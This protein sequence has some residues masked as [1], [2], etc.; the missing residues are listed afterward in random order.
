M[1]DV[2]VSILVP[3]VWGR[4]MFGGNIVE[5]SIFVDSRIFF[6]IAY[7]SRFISVSKNLELEFLTGRES[8]FFVWRRMF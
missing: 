7:F 2:N 8:P 5:N 4:G 6:S 3:F 1:A